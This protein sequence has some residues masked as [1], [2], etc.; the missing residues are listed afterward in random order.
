[1]ATV[2]EQLLGFYDL[3]QDQKNTWMARYG[4]S[5]PYF[6]AAQ[7]GAL[8]APP[9]AQGFYGLP[10]DQQATWYGEYGV[11]APQEWLHQSGAAGQG[12]APP[13]AGAPGAPAAGPA[14]TARYPS[15]SGGQTVRAGATPFGQTVAPGTWNP[16]SPG[17]NA[18]WGSIG[19]GTEG[20]QYGYGVPGFGQAPIPILP[21]YQPALNDPKLAPG[22]IPGSGT[23]NQFKL[24]QPGLVGTMAGTPNVNLRYGMGGPGD[25]STG[26]ELQ[27]P[28]KFATNSSGGMGDAAWQARYGKG[29][30]GGGGGAWQPV[31][32]YAG[33]DVWQAAGGGGGGMGGGEGGAFSWQGNL[34]GQWAPLATMIGRSD[35]PPYGI[36]TNAVSYPQA[37]YDL[38]R[39]AIQQGVVKV[40]PVGWQF[41]QETKGI[42]PQGWGIDPAQA[43]GP[44]GAPGAPGVGGD[45]NG[46]T[47]YYAQQAAVAQA[48]QAMQQ[49]YSE[50]SMS[51]GDEKL[52][53]QKAQEAWSRTFQEAQQKFNQGVSEA[54]L[55]G[56]YNGQ[57]TQAAQQQAW[58]Q[59]YQDRGQQQSGAISLL[60][61]QSRLQGPQD[62]LKYQQLNASTPQGLQSAL[63]ALAGNYNLAGSNA[64]GTPGPASLTSRI[65][66]LTSNAQGQAAPAAPG[67]GELTSPNQ[68]ALRN[69]A[70]MSPSQQKMVTGLYGGAGYDQE[71]FL[72][73]IQNAAP[74]YSGPSAGT[75]RM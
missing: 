25:P 27:T 32:G 49:A 54:G 44:G 40:N 73:Q 34:Q 19:A 72:K 38:L 70:T 9:E 12:N 16:A 36:A 71:D 3:P 37:Y 75:V 13:A 5:A 56:Q 35:S 41:L 23:Y 61:L 48:N 74:R 57:Q 55:T 52:A 8:Q 1:M 45:D 63:G 26:G 39:Q 65:G 11:A 2:P 51:S 4:A 68:F 20:I 60:D 29:G 42:T 15:T 43:A 53:M 22:Y 7:S 59:G 6:W 17:R 18:G 46:L 10:E 69:W 28:T 66:D 58:S 31:D 33:V 50:W 47:N 21:D 67:A 30:G 24:D 14:G 64:Q 62:W